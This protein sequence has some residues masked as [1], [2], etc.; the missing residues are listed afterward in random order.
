LA[1]FNLSVVKISL[2]G[3]GGE[4]KLVAAV[5][6]VSVANLASPQV[7]DGADLGGYTLHMADGAITADSDAAAELSD[8]GGPLEIQATIHF[9]P[10]GHSGMLSGTMRERPGAPPGLHRELESLAQLH[11]RDAAGRIPVDLEFTF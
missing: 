11:P 8:T 5:G 2:A 7:A 3:A 9:S 1:S 4:P 6:D 10:T